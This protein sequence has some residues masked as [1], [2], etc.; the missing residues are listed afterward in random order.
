MARID[1]IEAGHYRIPLEVALSDST[2]G[3]M[4]SFEFLTIRVRDTEGAEGVGYTY[5]TDAMVRPYIQ[6]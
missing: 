1:K 6:F 2:H 4:T 3:I 5:T